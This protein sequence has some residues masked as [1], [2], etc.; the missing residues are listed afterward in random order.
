[1]EI[2]RKRAIIIG[3][4]FIIATIA[5]ILSLNFAGPNKDSADY[6]VKLAEAE[7]T[8]NLGVLFEMLMGICVVGVSITF[9]PILKKFSP[10]LSMGYFGARLLESMIYFIDV[11]FVL[12]LVT[13]SKEFVASGAADP[14]FFHTLAALLHAARDWAGHVV[15]DIALFNM[16]AFILYYLLYKTRLIPRWIAVWGFL[17]TILYTLAAV[18]VLFGAEP[19]S[20]LTIGLNVPLG[21]N[22]MFL[23]LWLIIKGFTP[24]ALK[25]IEEK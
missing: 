20:P 3:V 7:N 15:L 13:L 10:S 12:L 8:V 5:G 1:M 22:E 18:L 6:L 11:V 9:Y 4:L 2:Y 25:A 24:S 19:M 23:A 14:T 17:G 21:L 16:S